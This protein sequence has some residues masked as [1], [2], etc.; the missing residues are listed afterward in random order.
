MKKTL[1]GMVIGFLIGTMSI[2]TVAYAKSATENI[3]VR[4]DNIKVY[5][6]NVLS[7]LK[8][9]NGQKIEPFIYNGTTYLPLRGA[10][11]LAGLGVTWDGATKS[12]YLWDEMTASDTYLLDVCQ[13]YE[14]YQD[15]YK[16]VDGKSFEMAGKKYSNGMVLM[17]AQTFIGSA[18]F[19]LD[20]KYSTLECTVGHVGNSDK[21]QSVSFIVDGK[22]VKEVTV[23][24]GEMPKSISIPLNYGLQ[25]KIVRDD[26][27]TYKYIGLGN[28]TVH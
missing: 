12:V 2:G 25:L 21:E 10:A 14:G 8:D 15:I 26:N 24:A 9:S 17:R 20:G 5:K 11:N 3:S 1:Q 7:D 13:P 4:Y 23:E 27:L 16:Q 22:L 18:L 6:D 28:I 19:N